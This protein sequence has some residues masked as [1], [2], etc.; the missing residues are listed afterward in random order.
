MRAPR[1]RLGLGSLFV[2][3]LV[4]LALGVGTVYAAIPNGSGTYSACLV[5]AT[6]TVRLINFPKVDTCPKGQKLIDWKRTGPQGAAGAAGAQGPQG[7]PGAQ[8]APGPQGPVG[9][10]GVTRIAFQAIFVDE[11][12]TTAVNT[13]TNSN[14]RCP[15]G[16]K[17]TGGGF[18]LTGFGA[19][20][21]TVQVV[22]SNP[23]GQ[24]WETAVRKVA[25]D[26]V[27]GPPN[28]RVY[29]ICMTTDPSAVIATASHFKVAKKHK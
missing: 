28:V 7:V 16:S 27:A 9:T 18:N 6:G 17:V 23:E 19:A 1:S 25:A 8:G 22:R 10:A 20:A 13:T 29:A 11:L 21:P 5:K 4:V 2:A 14:A 26:P 12:A 24:G 3:L 15:D